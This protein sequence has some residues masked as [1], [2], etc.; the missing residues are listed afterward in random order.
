MSQNVNNDYKWRSLQE[1]K[2]KCPRLSF[3]ATILCLCLYL[4]PSSFLDREGSYIL[5]HFHKNYDA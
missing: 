3:F 1:F 2:L 5:E 4:Y